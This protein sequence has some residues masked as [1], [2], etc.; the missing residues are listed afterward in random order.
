M[1]GL[2]AVHR[3]DSHPGK[4]SGFRRELR[5]LV[6]LGVQNIRCYFSKSPAEGK[7]EPEVPSPQLN[8]QRMKVD[9][10]M[11]FIPVVFVSHYMDAMPPSGQIGRQIGGVFFHAAPGC[12]GRGNQKGDR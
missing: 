8:G 6:A 3:A 1:V 5:S 12:A 7:L 9:A 2:G 11:E 4:A 10:G